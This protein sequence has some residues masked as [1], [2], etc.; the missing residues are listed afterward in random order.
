ML[1]LAVVQRLATAFRIPKLQLINDLDQENDIIYFER[2]REITGKALYFYACECHSPEFG[3]MFH[4]PK[5]FERLGF[6]T[7]Y[8]DGREKVEGD[9]GYCLVIHHPKSRGCWAVYQ[10]DFY[11]GATGTVLKVND[12]CT[13]V[14]EPF[15]TYLRRF[16]PTHLVGEAEDEQIT[17]ADREDTSF[18]FDGIDKS[19]N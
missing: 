17:N 18:L 10:Q 14:V 2:V 1:K 9:S 15:K 6:M 11:A 12:D 5:L 19:S 8:N 7:K 3:K 13:F 4:N 16:V